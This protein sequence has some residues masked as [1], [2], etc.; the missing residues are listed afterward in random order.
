M[1]RRPG[2]ET[3][4]TER[5][6]SE[7]TRSSPH[8]RMRKASPRLCDGHAGRAGG[9][10]RTRTL[11][12]SCCLPRNG[13]RRIQRSVSRIGS[14][15]ARGTVGLRPARRRRR[16]P[17][18]EPITDRRSTRPTH[19]THTSPGSR[20]RDPAIV[21]GMDSETVIPV[22]LGHSGNE[23]AANL[24]HDGDHHGGR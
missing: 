22:P 8:T 13:T 20:G 1:E 6:S 14:E 19:H 4:S 10:S 16:R 9:G 21:H 24:P 5:R 7:W 3:V 17:A 11:T 23:H 18:W 15:P 12:R 2:P